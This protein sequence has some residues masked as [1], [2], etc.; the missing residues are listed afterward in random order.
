MTVSHYNALPIMDIFANVEQRDLGGVASD[1][2]KIVKS[3]SRHL[4]AGV[5]IVLSGQVLTMNTSFSNLEIGIGAAV[6]FVYLLMAMNFQS[7]T[8]PFVILMA[9]PGA[10]A[11][12]IWVLFLTQTTFNV[13]S[14]MGALM[15]IGVATANSI[16]VVSFAN[17]SR[18]EGANKKDAR[19][20]ALIAG[21]TRLRPVCMT[22]L[23]MIIGMFPMAL[24]LGEGGEQNA[25][26]GRA[27]IGG[28]LFATVGTLIIVPVI[29]SILAKE[30][31]V[32]WEKRIDDEIGRAQS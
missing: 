14:L 16:L 5:Q 2:Q 15:T 24:S 32:N 11:G 19:A 1:V 26:I 13:P 7:W 28:L 31:L 18:G 3:N 23:A 30:P 25:P 20:A 21:S 22:A 6:V 29:Y 12:I 9:L 10:F 8:I 4:P 17:E 27:V